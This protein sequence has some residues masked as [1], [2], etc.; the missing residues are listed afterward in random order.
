MEQTNP[1]APQYAPPYAALSLGEVALRCAQET[2]KFFQNLAY[3]AGYCFELFRRAV[4]TGDQRAWDLIYQ[5]YH[6]QVMRW[7]NRHP[8]FSACREEA[9]YFVN[10]VFERLWRSLTPEK[11]GNFADLK[12]VLAYLQVCVHSLIL[13][14][15]VRAR[16]APGADEQELDDLLERLPY[17]DGQTPEDEALAR[18]RQQ[19]LW[20]WLA[21]RLKDEQ[22]RAVVEGLFV[23]ELKPRQMPAAYPGLFASVQ[24]VYRLKQNVLDRLRRDSGLGDF[25][26]R[27]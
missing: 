23:F 11:F 6:A 5:Q 16:E 3:E 27:T 17:R 7:V 15:C 8:A 14:D 24:E 26:D 25:L 4:V 20:R 22:E 2:Q 9:Q 12:R 21:G 13:D 1:L 19:R 10:R 18:S